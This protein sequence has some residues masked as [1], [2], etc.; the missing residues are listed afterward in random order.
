M[1]LSLCRTTVD[2]SARE[3]MEHGTAAFPIA[4]YHD[5][6]QA[7]PVPW[8]WH[9]ELEV[10]VVS[11]GMIL[12]TAGGEKFRLGKGEGLFINA[13]V[14]HGDWPLNAGSCRLHSMV[15]HPRLVGGNPDSVFWQKYLQPLLTDPSRPCAVLRPTVDWQHEAIEDMERA[16]RAVVNEIPGYEFKTRAALSEMI[17]QLVSHAPAVQAMPKK[18]L[19]HIQNKAPGPPTAMAPVTP[20][21]FPG[22]T[23]MAELRKNA[24]RGVMPTAAVFRSMRIRRPLRK[25]VTW[26][27]PVL[28]LKKI[29]EPM[30]MT[31]AKD[32]FPKMGMDAYQSKLVGNPHRKSAIGTTKSKT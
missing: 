2:D 17:F 7:E 10:L 1:A 9:E 25:W 31:M 18:A 5:D 32:K 23:R 14:L 20:M 16:F 29:P 13:G 26:I 15:F 28:M 27:N 21:I 3:L 12:A 8:H 11:E 6:L 30:R 24:A 4:C 22:P 19:T